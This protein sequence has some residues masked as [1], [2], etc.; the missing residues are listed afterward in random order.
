[1]SVFDSWGFLERESFLSSIRTL[2]VE[3]VEFR[4]GTSRFQSLKQSSKKSCD[5]MTLTHQT[6]PELLI[7]IQ[8]SS[9]L[10]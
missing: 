6:L 10:Y 7:P 2:C 5:G 4:Q 1:M 8:I 9:Y 3:N